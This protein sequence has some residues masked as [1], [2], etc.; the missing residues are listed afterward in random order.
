ML[1]VLFR[2]CKAQTQ[3]MSQ[4]CNIF[5]LLKKKG[6]FNILSYVKKINIFDTQC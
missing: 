3:D 6:L 5:V 4:Q 2:K 1:R